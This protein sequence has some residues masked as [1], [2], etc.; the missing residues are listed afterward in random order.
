MVFVQTFSD[1]NPILEN[2]P[3]KYQL[4]LWRKSNRCEFLQKQLKYQAIIE[5]FSEIIVSMK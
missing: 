2:L 4:P 3:S 1:D 5:I